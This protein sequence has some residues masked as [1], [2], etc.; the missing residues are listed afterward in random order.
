MFIDQKIDIKQR[1][2]FL[3]SEHQKLLKRRNTPLDSSNGLFRRWKNAVVT[4]DHVPLTWRYDLNINRN[5]YMIERIGVNATFNAGAILWENKYR[6]I[7]R[8]E[9]ND[10][11]SYF[12]I[13][14]SDNGVDGF[15]FQ[16][17]PLSLP[18]TQ[19]SETN[20][21]DMRLTHHE[22]GYVYGLFCVTQSLSM[23]SMLCILALSEA[24]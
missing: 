19:D 3:M 13:A 5:P 4:K 21:Y 22:D 17:R 20:V 10:R 23:A 7:V 16:P 1:K 8:V 9:G 11:K 14:D 12:A 24:L 18:Q 15:E 2:A 6:L